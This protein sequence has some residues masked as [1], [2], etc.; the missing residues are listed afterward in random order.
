LFISQILRISGV[1]H[2]AVG[3]VQVINAIEGRFYVRLMDSSPGEGLEGWKARWAV[4]RFAALALVLAPT[5]VLP[6]KGAA[7]EGVFVERVQDAGVASMLVQS[8]EH[9][10]CSI[11][12]AAATSGTA[13]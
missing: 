2:G 8:P 13:A 1:A 4:A 12:H 6:G 9:E 11:D 3:M 5:Q 10:Q 7:K